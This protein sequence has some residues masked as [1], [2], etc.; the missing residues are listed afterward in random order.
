MENETIRYLN[1][2]RYRLLE[3]LGSGGFGTVWKALDQRLRVDVAIKELAV[4]GG[5]DDPTFA[6]RVARA[7]RE[8]R[9][10]V[11]LRD[12]PHV[13]SVHDVLTE[14][15]RP[16]IVMQLVSGRSLAQILREDGPLPEADVARIAVEVIDALAAAH[17][18][19]ITHRDVKP[20]NIMLTPEGRAVLVDFGI[21]VQESD[22][23]ITHGVIGTLAYTAPERFDG[24]RGT[25]ASD[26][27][28]LGATLYHVVEGSSPFA[29]AE[30]QAT[31]HA[32]LSENPPLAQRAPGLA[33]VLAGLLAKDPADRLTLMAARERILRLSPG[34]ATTPRPAE[35]TPAPLPPT[36]PEQPTA[37]RPAARPTRPT[38]APAPRPDKIQFRFHFPVA[39]FLFSLTLLG[40]GIY[41]C[42]RAPATPRSSGDIF[43]ILVASIGTPLGA[44]FF[45][46][47]V[48]PSGRLT[49]DSKGITTEMRGIRPTVNVRWADVLTIRIDQGVLG[50]TAR[51]NGKRSPTTVTVCQLDRL[52][53]TTP[54]QIEEALRL[55]AGAAWTRGRR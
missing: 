33:P 44:I 8:A 13:V 28:S 34:S 36:R 38:P 12:H 32:V 55:F 51:G 50:L 14:R 30:Q 26:A 10:V 16:W 35:G 49:L 20:A 18:L 21:A 41:F 6:E 52:V 22:T 23:N 29:R 47:T 46:A 48:L 7:E 37:A 27:F 42:T 11:K 39:F 43:S 31:L 3:P 40:I 24:E 25:P 45:L 2:E 9:N 53:D 1:G 5:V 54:A 17:A 19:G 15:G 4:P